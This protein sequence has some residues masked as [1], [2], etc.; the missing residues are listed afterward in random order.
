MSGTRLFEAIDALVAD[1]RAIT[2][3]GAPSESG[4][5]AVYDGPSET[6]S[7]PATYVVV[8]GR[9]PWA[10]EDTDETAGTT[11]A[12]WNSLPITSGSQ[13][14][15]LSIPCAVVAESG[16]AEWSTL[17]TSVKDILDDLDAALRT[18]SGLGDMS[19]QIVL[20]FNNGR[21]TQSAG[22]DGVAVAF[23]FDVNLTILN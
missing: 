2:G 11:D 20:T 18:A 17:R 5:I 3:Y 9:S 7:A 8:G 14:E 22:P 19:Q 21:L 10:D 13:R 4:V 15:S 6:G 12:E 16:S 1:W 23:E